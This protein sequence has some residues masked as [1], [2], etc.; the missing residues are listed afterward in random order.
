MGHEFE[1]LVLE[2]TDLPCSV[3]TDAEKD[4]WLL[5]SPAE[6]FSSNT[7]LKCEVIFGIEPFEVFLQTSLEKIFSPTLNYINSKIEYIRAIKSTNFD[8]FTEKAK[9][10]FFNSEFKV[11]KLSDRMGMRLKGKNLENKVSTNIKS[12]GLVKGVVQ[13]P[14]DGNPII[15][16]ADHG[17]IGGYPKI[18][19]V[20][21]AD[22]DKLVQ[23]I[24]G[25]TIKFKL[26]DLPVAE[27]AFQDYVR[28]F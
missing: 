23:K 26:V 20:I 24:P 27:K 22:Y 17:T 10:Y 6:K 5:L 1:K 19:N 14:S 7:I 15:M 21:T 4:N 16:L 11:T 18:A 25:T 9:G 28:K 3:Q 2:K 13:V 12:E 8:Y